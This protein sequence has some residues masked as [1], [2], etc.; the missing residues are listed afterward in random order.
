M[1]K[2]WSMAPPIKGPNIRVALFVAA[3]NP[4]A[5]E[6]CP[7]ETSPINRRRIGMSVAQK[8]PLKTE[9]MAICVNVSSPLYAIMAFVVATQKMVAMVAA[10][11][12]LR[13][14]RSAMPP[15]MGPQKVSGSPHS[16]GTNETRNGEPV[17]SN[18]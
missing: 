13:F 18:V 8:R 14:T 4:I 6:R 17:I 16:T 7:P 1:P 11:S 9:A 2:F 10:N 12:T 15:M 5:A 3:S